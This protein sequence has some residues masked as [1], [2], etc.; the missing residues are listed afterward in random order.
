[1]ERRPFASVI[2]HAWVPAAGALLLLTA[3][4][5]ARRPLSKNQKPYRPPVPKSCEQNLKQ[6]GTAFLM[7]LQDWNECLPPAD[8]WATAL[9]PYVKHEAAWHCPEHRSPGALSYAMNRRLGGK[10]VK[11]LENWHQVLLFESSACR[12]NVADEGDSLCA[13]ARHRGGNFYLF[14]DGSIARHKEPPEF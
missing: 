2:R 3:S 6:L 10:S 12:R 9:K 4:H 1:M 8:R 5:A 14:A 7:Y 11:G 13:P